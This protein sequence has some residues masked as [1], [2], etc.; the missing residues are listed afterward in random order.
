[1]TW[2]LYSS[3]S[4]LF[5]NIPLLLSCSSILALTT[6]H[7]K[8]DLVEQQRS[9]VLPKLGDRRYS[10]PRSQPDSHRPSIPLMHKC[11][12][13]STESQLKVPFRA[14]ALLYWWHSSTSGNMFWSCIIYDLG[15]IHT[16][17]RDNF[18]SFF[19]TMDRAHDL[20]LPSRHLHPWVKSRAPI[21]AMFTGCWKQPLSYSANCI[22]VWAG[23]KHQQYQW[24]KLC[25]LNRCPMYAGLW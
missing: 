8:P 12:S 21:H 4:V 3:F 11:Q 16:I 22:N 20:R 14:W 2:I 19:G 7:R 1:M 15:F 25:V 13:L 10:S 23:R 5:K 18:F 17:M 6:A 9:T 24:G